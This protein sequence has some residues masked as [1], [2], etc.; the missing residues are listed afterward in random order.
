MRWAGRTADGNAASTFIQHDNGPYNAP[1]RLG[2][3]LCTRK[4]F[5]SRSPVHFRLPLTTLDTR[6]SRPVL[7]VSRCTY[8][9]GTMLQVAVMFKLPLATQYGTGGQAFLPQVADPAIDEPPSLTM[10]SLHSSFQALCISIRVVTGH[11]LEA[12]AQR[13]YIAASLLCSFPT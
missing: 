2:S 6:S 7:A 4:E 9:A 1:L 5:F 3:Q 8:P 13:P 10:H 12:K 11:C